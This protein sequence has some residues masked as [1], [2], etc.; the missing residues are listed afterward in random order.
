MI[1]TGFGKKRKKKKCVLNLET[2]S[3][4]KKKS[5]ISLG[6]IIFKILIND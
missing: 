4:G 3:L 1:T 2:E 5:N 6:N